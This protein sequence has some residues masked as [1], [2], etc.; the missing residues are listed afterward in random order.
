MNLSRIE[1]ET[2]INYNEAEAT[3]SVYTHKKSL[4]KK[5]ST[6]AEQRPND[7]KL[8]RTSHDGLAME[9]EIPKRWVKVNASKILTDEQKEKLREQAKRLHAEN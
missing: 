4:Q 7:C 9:F 1:Q 3:A 5:L 2:I 6:L 8:L